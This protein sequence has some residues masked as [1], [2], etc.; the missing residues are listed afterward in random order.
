[1][2]WKIIFALYSLGLFCIGWLSV[3]VE[4]ENLTNTSNI[5]ALQGILLLVLLYFDK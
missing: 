4:H 3:D 2:F 1:M 5:E